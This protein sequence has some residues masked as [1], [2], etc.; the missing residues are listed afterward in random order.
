MASFLN[1]MPTTILFFSGFWS[2]C[3]LLFFTRSRVFPL[4]LDTKAYQNDVPWI[5]LLMSSLRRTPTTSSNF[6]I[7][8]F[9]LDT[10]LEL[11]TESLKI[12]TN[13]S[14]LSG[15]EHNNII[16]LTSSS[17]VLL[18]D[19]NCQGIELIQVIVIISLSCVF[20]L[21]I[22]F[23]KNNDCLKQR[24]SHTCLINDPVIPFLWSVLR[25]WTI[26]CLIKREWL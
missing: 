2:S 24:A 6:S 5:F 16:A 4:S 26:H 9:L 12:I 20:K 7:L 10:K 15:N 19:N 11:D 8:T 3:L 18:T 25:H 1:T 23:I 22:F 17:S 14:H 13:P 21:N